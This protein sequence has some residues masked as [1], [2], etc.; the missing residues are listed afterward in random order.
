[1]VRTGNPPTRSAGRSGRPWRRVRAQVLRASDVC[2][3][4]GH[5]GSDTVDHLVPLSM[6]GPPLDRSNLA[7]AHGV[8]PCGSCGRRCN[9]SRGDGRTY[10]GR[11]RQHV[12]PFPT[13]RRW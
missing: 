7:P 5:P 11:P 9:P 6:G 10:R 13:S 12:L 4:C 8:N 3:I 1:M 2:W